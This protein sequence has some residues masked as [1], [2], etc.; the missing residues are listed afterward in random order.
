MNQI[1]TTVADIGE[2]VADEADRPA[3]IVAIHPLIEEDHLSIRKRKGDIVRILEAE[4]EIEI[5]VRKVTEVLGTATR[6]LEKG[7]DIAP[8]HVPWNTPKGKLDPFQEKSQAVVRA[9]R[10][11]MSKLMSL[12]NLKL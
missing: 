8:D 12:R 11:L 10:N 5:V 9:V 7:I 2:N 3:Q 1:R 4:V 6:K